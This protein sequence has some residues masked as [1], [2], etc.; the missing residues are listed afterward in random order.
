MRWRPPLVGRASGQR[1]GGS[2]FAASRLLPCLS[3]FL[4]PVADWA[5]D[6]A[7]ET[8]MRGLSQGYKIR[9]T[10]KR[11]GQQPLNLSPIPAGS[12]FGNNRCFDGEPVSQRLELVH[13]G[14]K[15]TPLTC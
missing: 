14:Y 4:R 8:N 9:Y 6:Q 5:L 12:Q 13:A 11:S 3:P 7:E 10:V 15:R 2:A 1:E